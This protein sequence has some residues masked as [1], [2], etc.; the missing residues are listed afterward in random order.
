MFFVKNH[1]YNRFTLT[2]VVIN[3]RIPTIEIEDASSHK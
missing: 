2:F 3:I 1:E